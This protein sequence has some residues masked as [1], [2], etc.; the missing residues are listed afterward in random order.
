MTARQKI[1]L[2]AGGVIFAACIVLLIGSIRNYEGGPTNRVW[3][4]EHQHWHYL[5]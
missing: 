3:S 1:L 2:L 5:D 4:E